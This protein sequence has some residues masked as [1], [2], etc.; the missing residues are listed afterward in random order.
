MLASRHCIRKQTVELDVDSEGLALALQPRMSELNQRRWLPVIERVL[1]D[2]AEPGRRIRLPELSVDLGTLSFAELERETEERLDRE[3]RRALEEALRELAA[4]R[5]DGARSRSE[6]MARVEVLEHYLL[7]G[8]LPYWAP[9]ARKFSFS[10]LLL[11]ALECEPRGLAAMLFEHGRLP[12]VLERLVLQLDDV[13]L[14]RL[15][16]LLEPRHAALIVHYVDDLRADH[17]R[18]PLVPLSEAS[19]DDL[20]WR[21][22]LTYLTRDPGSQF[23]RK[24]FVQ[25][26][27]EGTAA[28]TGL[29]YRDLLEALRAGLE[30]TARREPVRTSLPGVIRELTHDLDRDEHR[31]HVARD[32]EPS[33]VVLRALARLEHF[34]RSGEVPPAWRQASGGLPAFDG[35]LRFL[36]L[37]A[38]SRT[39]RLLRATARGHMT[40]AEGPPV[41]DGTGSPAFADLLLQ[42]FATRDVVDVLIPGQRSWVAEQVERSLAESGES[43]A[44]AR[45]LRAELWQAIVARGLGAADGEVRSPIRRS[46]DEI[47]AGAEAPPSPPPALELA[48]RRRLFRRWDQ[49]HKLR[50]FLRYGVLPWDA[51]LEDPD[52]SPQRALDE[53]IDLPISGQRAVLSAGSPELRRRMLLRAAD[54]MSRDARRRWLIRL[55]PQSGRGDSPLGTALADHLRRAE[56]EALF[57][58]RLVEAVL[59]EQLLDLEAMAVADRPRD[60]ASPDEPESWPVGRLKSVLVDRLRAEAEP[61]EVASEEAGPVPPLAELARLLVEE[62]PGDARQLVA[63]LGAVP[64]LRDRW[65]VPDLAEGL[66]AG[67]GEPG[68]DS[69]AAEQDQDLGHAALALLAGEP[70]PETISDDGLRHALFERLDNSPDE[71]IPVLLRHAAD[72]RRR[73]HWV[74]TLPE[75]L[76]ARLGHL[77]EPRRHRLLLDALEV[78]FTAWSQILPSGF[79]H[80]ADRRQL[81]RFLFEYL[82]SERHVNRSLEGLVGAFFEDFVPRLA[83]AVP[84]DRGRDAAT[85]LRERTRQLARRAGQASL[86]AALHRRPRAAAARERSESAPAAEPSSADREPSRPRA[87]DRAAAWRRETGEEP[88]EAGEPIYIDN[89]GLALAGPFLPQFFQTLGLPPPAEDGR[90]RWPDRA[91]ASRAVH[92]TQYLVD[93][94]TSTAEPLLILNKI[95]CGVPTVAPIEPRIDPQD[96]ELEACQKLLDSII[97]HWEPIASIAA[98]RQTFLQREGSL[99]RTAEGW[100]LQVQRKTVDVLLDQIPWTWSVI[101]HRWMSEALH[102]TW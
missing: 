6:E 72:P 84:A 34:L 87:R 46:V 71:V 50:R 38:A 42:T 55:L 51:W 65:L 14:E 83:S 96:D 1:D 28:R 89:A 70:P 30:R 80:L 100:R 21:L 25:S 4:G 82:A 26:L 18:E 22:T 62:Y 77:L 8:S 60:S 47:L 57:V 66:L 39:R 81:W 73:E 31:Q 75:P 85:A 49:V 32:A 78:L 44:E 41:P 13:A 7:N 64:A 102:V 68:T 88:G 5:L 101:R 10:E 2:F 54:G 36:A 56:D 74:K 19:Y 93:G 79:R 43:G 92:L 52:A 58:A 48:E 59:D 69:E 53:L 20:L 3:L 86:L 91:A 76:L 94:S 23:N 99:E 45:R 67:A 61:A 29:R 95:L 12:R 35:L 9:R 17:R 63:A 40:A 11:E 90:V 37:R 16:G 27:L 98:L 33:D 97:A 24:H 15:V